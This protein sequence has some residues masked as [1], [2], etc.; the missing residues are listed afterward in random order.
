METT[1]LPPFRGVSRFGLFEVDLRTG[2]LRKRGIRIALQEQ[3]L[4]ILAALL[5]A[6]GDIVSRDE[7]CRRVWP[8]GTFVDFEHSLNAAVRRLRTALGDT[9]DVP[10]FIET[11][12]RRGYR[13]VAL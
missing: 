1:R 13:F 5:E 7:L 6:R 2:E 10:R 9:A 12:H 4:R 11:V 3:P 8:E